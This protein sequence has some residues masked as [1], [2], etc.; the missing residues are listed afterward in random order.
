MC[1]L[2][3]VFDMGIGYGSGEGKSRR[4]SFGYFPPGENRGRKIA[5]GK[6]WKVGDALFIR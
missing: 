6:G 4:F 2:G 3:W 5:N 1:P